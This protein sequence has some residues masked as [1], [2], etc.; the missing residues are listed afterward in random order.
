[1]EDKILPEESSS[2]VPEQPLEIPSNTKKRNWPILALIMLAIFLLSIL[3]A[4]IILI[5]RKRNDKKPSAEYSL[6]FLYINDIH[7][8]A[9][10]VE[11]STSK[12][13]CRSAVADQVEKFQFGQYECDAPHKLYNSLID[14][15]KKFIESPDFI[16]LGGDLIAHGLNV[17][18]QMLIDNFNNITNPIEKKYPNTKIY[19]TLGNNDFQKNYGSFDTDLTDFETV[20]EIF[21][22]WMNTEQAE[23][24]KKGGYYYADFPSSN[25]RFLFLNTVIYS[26]KRTFNETLTDPYD[27]FAW[28]RKMYKDAVQKGYKVGIALHIPPGVVYTDNK[29][30]WNLKYINTFAEIMKEC[31]FSFIISGHSHTDMILP[32]YTPNSDTD[33]ILYSLSAPSVSP[34]HYNNP[35]FRHYLLDQEII[36]DFIQYYADIMLN[37]SEL[38]WEIEYKFSEAYKTQNITRNSINDAVKWIRSTGEGQWRYRER[39]YSR[40]DKHNSFYYCTLRALLP[41]DV[42]KCAKQNGA[43][44]LSFQPYYHSKDM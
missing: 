18:K 30:G 25:F 4:T 33:N 42:T 40:A 32:L 39:V 1:M 17:T 16:L 10:Y 26:R 34:T 5:V 27:Q 22:K 37:P 13:G 41:D 19:I 28:I 24:F 3:I 2:A 29:V 15:A 44:E 38:N 6:N 35:G 31:D 21:G 11:T 23:T 43:E 8:D 9:T 36:K 12:L 14:N 7:L 20:F